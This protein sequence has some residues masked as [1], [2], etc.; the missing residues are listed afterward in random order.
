MTE[1]RQE[2]CRLAFAHFYD[3]VNSYYAGSTK[4]GTPTF[5]VP[6]NVRRRIARQKAKQYLREARQVEEAA[7]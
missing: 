7:A 5:S 3:D 2:R 6:R 1:S 4:S